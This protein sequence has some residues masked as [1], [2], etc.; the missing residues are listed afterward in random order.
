[1]RPIQ[2]QGSRNLLPV[3]WPEKSG[4]LR[5]G[6]GGIW[7]VGISVGLLLTAVQ[8]LRNIY[9]AFTPPDA[10]QPSESLKKHVAMS[11]AARLAEA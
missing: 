6:L 5:G 2:L 7:L 9:E 1:M 10:A 4:S 11:L 8:I 3:V